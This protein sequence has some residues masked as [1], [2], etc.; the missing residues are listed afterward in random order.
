MSLKDKI[1]KE[2]AALEAKGK[3]ASAYEK[4]QLDNLKLKL[5]AMD[6]KG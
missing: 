6:Q 2:V 1:T 3:D 4:M 5:A